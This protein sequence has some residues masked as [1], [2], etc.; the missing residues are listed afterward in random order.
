MPKG[1]RKSKEERA[2]WYVSN[3]EVIK[4]MRPRDVLFLM[5]KDKMYA[6]ASRNDA[7]KA[8]SDKMYE[9]KQSKL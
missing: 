7:V 1:T 3:W 8:I 5:I 6:W 2:A 4:N 9:I